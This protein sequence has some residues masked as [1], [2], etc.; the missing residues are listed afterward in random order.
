MGAI[1]VDMAMSLDG[2]AADE[3]HTALY[4]IEQLRHTPDLDPFIAV[5]PVRANSAG[6]VRQHPLS[7]TGLPSCLVV[8]V[9]QVASPAA[10]AHILPQ[11]AR[12]LPEQSVVALA[13]VPI[14]ACL[15]WSVF[16]SSYVHLAWLRCRCRA[17]R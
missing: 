8:A 12:G 13:D 2:F 5:A 9:P 7:V 16:Y 3:N 1:I 10:C 4:P 11:H 15:R 6:I 17:S 14:A